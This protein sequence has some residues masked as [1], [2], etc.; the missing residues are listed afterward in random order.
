MKQIP[1]SQGK[2]ALVDD[3]VFEYLMQWKWY[4]EGRYARMTNKSRRGNESRYM[5]KIILQ[6]KKGFDIDHING[7]KLDNRRCNLRQASRTQNILNRPMQTNN[8]TGFK[9]VHYDRSRCKFKAD[10]GINGKSK[11]IGRFNTAIEAA[12]AYNEMAKKHYGE[13][14]LL[15]EIPD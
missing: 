5:H 13:F 10:I 2:F 7:N 11:F 3:D 9:G 1:L 8:K 15:N 6:T 14:A 4:F 12:K